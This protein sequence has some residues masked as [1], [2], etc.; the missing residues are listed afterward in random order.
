M[1]SDQLD[2]HG[3]LIGGRYR[4]RLVE[5]EV[6]DILGDQL[7]VVYDSGREGRLDAVT[8]ARIILNMEIETAALEPHT[9]LGA[10]ERNSRY[11]T[12]IGFLASRTTM[13]EAIVPPIAQA[14]FVQ[15][16]RTI[17]GKSPQHNAGGYYVHHQHV[18]KWGN[19][20]RITFS[21]SISEL[22]ELDFGPGVEP[23]HNPGN[24]GSSWRINRNVFWWQLLRL[25]FNM[26]LQQDL[27]EIRR[28][29][30]SEHKAEFETGI[31]EAQ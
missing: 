15:T 5:Y 14:G 9:G 30:P 4:N 22:E 21:A 23:V 26:G 3:F 27:D 1:G 29:I 11:F 16:Y 31:R 17:T 10:S 18:D 12:S 13:M 25:G 7:R 8:Q 2:A 6:I 19:E 28:R 20:L 24:A